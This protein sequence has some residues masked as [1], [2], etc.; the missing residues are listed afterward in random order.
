MT[1]QKT[2]IFTL[3]FAAIIGIYAAGAAADKKV[4]IADSGKKYHC[5]DCR[6]LK[7][8]KKLTELT[9][10]EAQAKGYEACK[11]CNP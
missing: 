7:K 9:E 10:E 1:K 4:Y 8:T 3:L 2:V 11:V 5:Q 6:T